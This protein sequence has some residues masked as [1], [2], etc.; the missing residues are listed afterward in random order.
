MTAQPRNMVM[1]RAFIIA[2]FATA[3]ATT[4]VQQETAAVNR[5]VDDWHRA[6]AEADESRYFGHMSPDA[7]FG[8]TDA[9][10]RWDLASF[11][12]FAQVVAFHA[13]THVQ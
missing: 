6:A 12:A 1:R 9:T 10:E 7:V 3:C 8:G 11:R 5:V 13:S 4:N 2:L